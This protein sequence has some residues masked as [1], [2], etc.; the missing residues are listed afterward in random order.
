VTWKN[1]DRLLLAPLGKVLLCAAFPE[2]GTPKRP[3][4][5]VPRKVRTVTRKENSQKKASSQEKKKKNKQSPQRPRPYPAITSKSSN[6]PCDGLYSEA[7][8]QSTK[9]LQRPPPEQPQMPYYPQIAMEPMESEIKPFSQWNQTDGFAQ[10]QMISES[11]PQFYV[12]RHAYP[13]LEAQS[14]WGVLGTHGEL[15]DRQMGTVAAGCMT[16]PSNLKSEAMDGWG[17]LGAHGKV[18][19]RQMGTVAAGCMTDASNLESEAMDASEMFKYVDL[20]GCGV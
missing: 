6:D 17:V 18:V 5:Q 19:D 13:Q 4:P 3:T 20:D 2:K 9:T 7:A 14:G 16:E 10:R 1:R 11:P 12:E 15:V 8:A